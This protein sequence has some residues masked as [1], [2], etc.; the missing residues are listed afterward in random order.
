MTKDD[1]TI[2]GLMVESTADAVTLLDRD[3]QR[4]VLVRSELKELKEAA[5][6]LMPEGLLE[7]LSPQQ[8]MDLFS[9]LQGEGR[10]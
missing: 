10:K 6:S 5:H 1:R 7:A 9:H 4:Q 2:A 8:V 3:N